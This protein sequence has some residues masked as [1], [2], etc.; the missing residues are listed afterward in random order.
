MEDY[1]RDENINASEVYIL[2]RIF[3][4]LWKHYNLQRCASKTFKPIA[5]SREYF[6]KQV[7]KLLRICHLLHLQ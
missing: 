6:S 7:N 2:S 3:Q 4:F 1:L 5:D